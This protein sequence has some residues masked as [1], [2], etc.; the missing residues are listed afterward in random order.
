MLQKKTGSL[1][2]NKCKLLASIPNLFV[3]E[4]IDGI[5]KANAMNKACAA[6]T[7]LPL[8]VFLQINTSGETSTCPFLRP[9][10]RCG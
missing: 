4:T 8:R 1:Q 10:R 3:V 5:S 7:Q 9:V 6:R 2:S